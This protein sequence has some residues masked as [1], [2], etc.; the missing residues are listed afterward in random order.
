M[1]VL[2][3]ESLI[4]TSKHS[5]RRGVEP[6]GIAIHYTAGRDGTLP[7]N[8]N[9]HGKPVT[10]YQRVHGWAKAGDMRSS[11]DIC[12]AR[13]PNAEPTVQMTHTGS[14]PM[15]SRYTWHSGG[16]MS[17]CTEAQANR[18]RVEMQRAGFGKSFR[19]DPRKRTNM[20]MIGV[21]L[22]NY[23]Y[24]DDVNGVPCYRRTRKQK[25]PGRYYREPVP[26]SGPV[27]EDTSEGAAYRFWEAYTEASI[28]ELCRVVRAIVVACPALAT[29][30]RGV[31][32]LDIEN[33]DAS[34]PILGHEDI[35]GTKSDPGPAFDQWWR[36]VYD[37]AHGRL[38][39]EK[40]LCREA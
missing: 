21:D 8:Y 10:M 23:G 12:I 17:E 29:R 38:D 40:G 35:R 5:A 39:F 9:R 1:I 3:S 19:A 4:R 6:D 26:F 24:L 15:F 25:K 22:D 16:S 30:L 20:F 37:A 28:R 34:H 33:P 27:F 2:S 11:T 32:N 13:N 14:A 7:E 31:R 36:T 18:M